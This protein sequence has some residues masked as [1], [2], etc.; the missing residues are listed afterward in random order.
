[1]LSP[2]QH[3]FDFT[4]LFFNKFSV[5][6]QPTVQFVL[7]SLFVECHIYSSISLTIFFFFFLNRSFGSM[8]FLQISLNLNLVKEKLG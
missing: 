2:T 7:T 3:K 1:M 8:L 6:T 5:I 4:K